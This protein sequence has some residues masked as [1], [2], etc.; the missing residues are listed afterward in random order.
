M[1]GVCHI[2]PDIVFNNHSRPEKTQAGILT[3][4]N[5]DDI[6][7][8]SIPCL[9]PPFTTCLWRRLNPKK[10][11]IDRGREVI[12]PPDFLTYNRIQFSG[13]NGGLAGDMDV[14]DAKRPGRL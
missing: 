4:W 11:E 3:R 8:H 10:S 9:K 7:Y 12:V 6:L 13:I 2:R 5:S 1:E 14:M